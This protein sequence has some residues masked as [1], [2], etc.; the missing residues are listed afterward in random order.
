[1]KLN[2]SDNSFVNKLSVN[3][4]RKGDTY[5]STTT[6]I[7]VLATQKGIVDLATGT[8]YPATIIEDTPRYIYFDTQVIP[9]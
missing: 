7:V 1:M 3:Q 4:L 5:R 6:N 2:L 9:A 8:Y